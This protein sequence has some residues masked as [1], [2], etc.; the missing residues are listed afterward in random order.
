MIVLLFFGLVLLGVALTAAILLLWSAVELAWLFLNRRG[1]T[2][3]R[4]LFE[5]RRQRAVALLVASLFCGLGSVGGWYLLT[6]G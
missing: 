2:T 5:K 4:Q 3:S 1:F 6:S